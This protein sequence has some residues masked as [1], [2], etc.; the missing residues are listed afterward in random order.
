MFRKEVLSN[1]LTVLTEKMPHVRSVA[2]GV[3]I[4]RG[5]RHE[6]KSESGLAHF[7]EHMV[8]KGT[9]RRTQA[10]IAQEMGRP[11]Q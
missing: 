1:G 2:V 10:E 9:E 8:F 3:W 5:S 4:R 11:V 7:L 6:E